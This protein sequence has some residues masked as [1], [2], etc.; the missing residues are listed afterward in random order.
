MD[1]KVVAKLQGV[2]IYHADNPNITLTPRTRERAGEKVLENLDLE[3][4]AGDVV[5]L[6]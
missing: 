2:G 6:I 1:K 3:V 5:Y 4:K